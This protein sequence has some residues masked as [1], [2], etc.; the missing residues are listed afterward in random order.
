MRVY[1]H[2]NAEGFGKRIS[3]RAGLTETFSEW[4]CILYLGPDCLSQYDPQAFLFSLV[5]KP[6]WAPVKFDQT[7]KHSS[8]PSNSTYS[9]YDHGP[10]FG[11]PHHDLK[12][13]LSHHGSSSELGYTYGLPSGYTYASPSARTFL[14]GHDQFNPDEIETFYDAA[15][16]SQGRFED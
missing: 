16:T 3:E 7:G 14:A 13:H 2:E 11:G 9:C 10:I 4:L 6:G 5:N 8:Y 12:L 15:F 1:L